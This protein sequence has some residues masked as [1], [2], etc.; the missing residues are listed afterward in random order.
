[1]DEGFSDGSHAG[2]RISIR[3]FISGCFLM[4]LSF[5]L[6]L[7][8]DAELMRGIWARYDGQDSGSKVFSSLVT[9]LKRLVTEKPAL[10][11]VNQSMF[12]VGVPNDTIS[13]GLDGVAGRVATAASATV[14]GVVGMIGSSTG[15]SLQGSSMKLQ[16]FVSVPLPPYHAHHL[17]VLINSTRQTHLLYLKDMSISWPCSALYHYAKD[18]PLSPGPCIRQL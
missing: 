12:G 8:S 10:L 16:W 2:V 14:S 1:M 4:L 5:L 3:S 6:R 13:T 17:L 15:L 18:S 9:A 11:G 7:C